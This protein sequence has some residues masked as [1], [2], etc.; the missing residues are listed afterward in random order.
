[1][2]AVSA[3]SD[4]FQNQGRGW[5]GLDVVFDYIFSFEFYFVLYLYSN[6]LKFLIPFPPLPVDETIVFAGISILIGIRVI[7]MEGIRVQSLYLVGAYLLF[8]SFLLLSTTW[9]GSKIL[10]REYLTYYFSFQFWNITAGTAV[11]AT[12]RERCTR[13]INL[14]I[15]FSVVIGSAG[16]YIYHVFGSFRFYEGFAKGIRVYNRWGYAVAYGC[17]GAFGFFCLSRMFTSRQITYGL[18]F[19]I[20]FYFLIIGTS[21]GS[22]LSAL[23][24]LCSIILFLRP[25]IDENGHI[26]VHKVYILFFAVFIIGIFTIVYIVINVGNIETFGRFVKLYE[27]SE[28]TDLVFGPNRFN[29][30]HEAILHWLQAPIFGNGIADFALYGRPA[31]LEGAHPHN[32]VLELLTDGGIFGLLLFSL[33]LF[34]ALHKIGFS[35]IGND[36]LM[37]T[38]MMLFLSKMVAGM[39][40]TQICLMDFLFVSIGMLTLAPSGQ[41]APATWSDPLVPGAIR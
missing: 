21:R 2:S 14:V 34:V 28:N 41:D 7:I 31:E 37:L 10:S 4:V 32:M 19:V 33:I 25:W 27:Q 16:I 24:G 29:Y 26:L 11:L 6:A 17:V 3:R 9:S 20:A 40:S 15:L 39:Y 12:S 36:P 18:L 30:Y 13:F 1:M 23:A 8:I 5:Y 38:I 35:T 22:L